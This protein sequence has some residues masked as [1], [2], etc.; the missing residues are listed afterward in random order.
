MTYYL[1]VEAVNLSNIVFDTDDLSTIRGGGLILLHAIEKV[2]AM[3]EEKHP[4][5]T[6]Q[7]EDTQDISQQI[8]ALHQ[9]FDHV[10][11][12]P[13]FPS[14][15]KKKAEKR[16]LKKKIDQLEEQQR[17]APSSPNHQRHQPTI[18]KGASWGLFSLEC[19]ETEAIGLAK[20][21]KKIVDSEEQQYASFVVSLLKTSRSRNKYQQDKERTQTLNRWQ[22][23]N[24]PT[25]SYP[26]P[27]DHICDFDKVSPA[28]ATLGTQHISQ[29]AKIRREYGRTQKQTLYSNLTHHKLSFTNDLNQ[30]SSAENK[31]ILNGKIAFLYIDGNGFGNIQRN[32]RSPSEQK[33]FDENTR[34][35]REKLLEALLDDIKDETDWLYRADKDKTL[36]R[37]ETLLWG[38][39]EIIWIA[40][41]W[42]GWWL[43]QK[44]YELAE[45]Y[46]QHNDQALRHG[47]GLVFCHHNAPIARID[48]LARNLANQ[49]AKK[50]EFK[51]S[52]KI[53]YEILESFDHA[54]TNLHQYRAKQLAE[55]GS[56]D[57][58][59]ID[60]ENIAI[61]SN[62]V[63]Q[64]K[65]LDFPHRKIHQILATKRQCDTAKTEMLEGKLRASIGT[66]GN[67]LLD[68]FLSRHSQDSPAGWQ[69]LANFWD[70]C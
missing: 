67:S 34:L 32:C 15:K 56:I 66:E 45:R 65:S 36:V 47:A 23:L 21:A 6:Q 5:I 28:N 24:T 49:F 2:A 62:C 42:K 33:A 48:T 40:P 52:N 61:L 43:A 18:T 41:A 30:I 12:N 27:G 39:D 8:A 25:I 59:L 17:S 22:Q 60:A 20:S 51:T 7:T 1:Q 35:G 37:L 16:R 50:A 58:L 55:Q 13:K 63:R 53:A 10:P 69:H 64:L 46:I 19:D 9:E 3:L 29:S 44:F 11:Q 26:S 38:G 68:E 31:G 70:Y 4:N 54:G 14:G 57:D